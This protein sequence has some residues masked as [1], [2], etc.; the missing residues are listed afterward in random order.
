MRIY[1]ITILFISTLIF[2]GGFAYAALPGEGNGIALES[3]R[4]IYPGSANK[5]ITFTVTNQT[6]IT[7]LLQ[8]RV[9][10]WVSPSSSAVETQQD[11]Q[12]DRDDTREPEDVSVVVPF[13]VVP[14]LARFAPDDAITL[15]IQ[16]IQNTLPQDRESVFTFSLK[17]IPSQAAPDSSSVDRGTKMV[18]AMQN[19]L[20][21]FYRPKGLAVM[22]ADARARALQF[23]RQGMQLAIQN[24]T[25]YY[26]TLGEVYSDRQPVVLEHQR[27]LAPFSTTIFD[28]PST[29][30]KTICWQIIDD[31]GRNTPHQNRLLN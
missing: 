5:G 13:I 3:T 2:S 22:D 27:M 6:S 15:R 26:V 7:Y 8:S 30:P 19:N 21:L 31:I 14:P 28:S 17:A 12:A 1:S 23:T 10:P 9:V 24:P 4:V 25:P 11:T 18:L 29:Q 16:L 20:K